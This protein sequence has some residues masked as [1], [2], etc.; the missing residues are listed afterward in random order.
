MP[1]P[2]PPAAIALEDTGLEPHPDQPEDAGGGDPVRQHPQQPLVVIG[3]AD[4]QERRQRNTAY[5]LRLIAT[6]V[7]D[8]S[9]TPAAADALQF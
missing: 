6:N 2:E 7:A 4:L 9:Q 5:Q 1:D 3:R 8:N